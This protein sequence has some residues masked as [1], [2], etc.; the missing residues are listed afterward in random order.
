MRCRGMTLV[1]V[2]AALALLGGLL[3]ST[4][5]AKGR[6]DRGA[7]E[8]LRTQAAADAA[9]RLL[10]GWYAQDPSR[11]RSG[12][13]R[14]G[15]GQISGTDSEPGFVWKTSSEPLRAFAPWAASLDGRRLVE[16]G[17]PDPPARLDV[18][19]LRLFDPER[20]DGADASRLAVELVLPSPTQARAGA[21][22]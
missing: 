11:W 18:V 5:L 15:L 19:T 10:A 14:E 2:L 8:A 4:V 22:Q 1:E 21:P 3:A 13:P 16:G 20:V 6:L 12:V 9:D 7:H 17:R